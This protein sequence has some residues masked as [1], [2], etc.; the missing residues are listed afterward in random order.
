MEAK[1][2]SKD[3]TFKPLDA[4]VVMIESIKCDEDGV[5]TFIIRDP[6]S[7]TPLLITDTPQTVVNFLVEL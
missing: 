7:G 6:K 2:V 3:F 1:E 4:K 5:S